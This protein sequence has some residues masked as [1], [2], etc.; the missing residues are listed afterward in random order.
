M[1]L[2]FLSRLDVSHGSHPGDLVHRPE[3]H[4]DALGAE[5]KGAVHRQA[6]DAHEATLIH[7]RPDVAVV[8]QLR[9][10]ISASVV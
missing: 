4:V 9:V 7:A 3:V 1:T 8:R 10:A 6:V 5:A 2:L